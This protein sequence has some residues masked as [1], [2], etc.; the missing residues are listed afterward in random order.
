MFPFAPGKILDYKQHFHRL[1][2]KEFNS[3]FN[4]LM[5][6]FTDRVIKHWFNAH[7]LPFENN[8]LTLMTIQGTLFTD[9]NQ[10]SQKAKNI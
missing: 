8:N 9:G 6:I 3:I 5:F 10:T 1:T 7:I 2:E 4:S